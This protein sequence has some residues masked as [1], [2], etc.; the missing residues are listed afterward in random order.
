MQDVAARQLAAND[1]GAR[2]A[3]GAAAAEPERRSGETGAAIEPEAFDKVRAAVLGLFARRAFHKVGM[4]DIARE[5]GYGMARLY[6]M[7]ETKDALVTACLAPDF[8]ALAARLAEVSRREVGTRRRFTACLGELA[9]FD[10]E[11]PAF[12]RVVRVTT[13]TC[14]W[15]GEEGPRKLVDQIADILRAGKRDGSVRTDFEP[16]ALAGHALAMAGGL[17]SRWA[18]ED[19]G[20]APAAPRELAEERSKVL[21]ALIWPAVSAD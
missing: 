5:T 3:A 13:P 10:I 14:L 16:L 18:R 9:A 1:A 21:A 20:W 17:L 19:E 7:A 6:K 8:E 4:R 2:W 15:D 11:N 12:A